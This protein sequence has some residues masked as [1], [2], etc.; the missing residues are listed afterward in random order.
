MISPLRVKAKFY[1]GLADATR[2]AILESLLTGEKSVTE[3]VDATKQNQSNVSNHL[4]CLID[5]GLVSNN[6]NGKYIHYRIRDAGVR[7]LLESGDRI[8][9][10]VYSD[11]ARCVRY[12]E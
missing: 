1:R 6:R 7:R 10:K 3:I 9:S 5:C 11:I 8:V 12:E 2:L 4:K